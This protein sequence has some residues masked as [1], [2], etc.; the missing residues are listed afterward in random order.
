MTKMYMFVLL[1]GSVFLVS[2]CQDNKEESVS[3][4]E[5][6]ETTTREVSVESSQSEELMTSET[7]KEVSFCW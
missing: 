6:V 1:V 5:A 3:S 4:K 2:G 7:K